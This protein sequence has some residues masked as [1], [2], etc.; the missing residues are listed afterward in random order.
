MCR[1][2]TY[3]ILYY[4]WFINAVTAIKKA[5]SLWC[6]SDDGAVWQHRALLN[7]DSK[8][9]KVPICVELPSLDYFKIPWREEDARTYIHTR[10]NYKHTCALV[11]HLGS[12]WTHI[13]CLHT[14]FCPLAK[15]TM[16]RTIFPFNLLAPLLRGYRL[17]SQTSPRLCL[18]TARPLWAGCR[19]KERN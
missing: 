9:L 8:L 19:L 1:S 14:I 17:P 11:V 7:C 15:H 3:L 4:T 2:Y 13:H 18:F 12:A 6:D 5:P 10:D 16:T